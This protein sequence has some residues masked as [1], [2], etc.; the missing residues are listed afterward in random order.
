MKSYVVVTTI[1]IPYLLKDYAD[2]FEKFGH[3]NK[4][5]FIIIGDLKTP[6]EARKIS[7]ELNSR[8]FE[9]IYM[10]V[11]DQ[12]GW[13]KKFPEL[14]KIIPY[15]SD[16]RRNIG[17]LLAL[18]KGAEMILSIDDDNFVKP[19]EDWFAQHAIVGKIH[20]LEMVESSNGW[21]NICTLLRTVP[22]RIIYPRGY[23][24]S[25]R[26]KHSEVK[27]TRSKNRVVLNLGLWEGEPDVDAVT[28]L[29]ETVKVLSNS[30]RK[31]VLAKGTNSPINTQNTAV[32]HDAI[33]A[34]YYIPMGVTI[35]GN[36][37]DRYGDIWSGYFVKKV[38][39]HM[40]DAVSVGGPIVI[41]NRNPHDLLQDLK[42]ELAGM[43]LT[44][45]LVSMVDSIQ[46]TSKTYLDSYKE[47]S[48]KLKETV[49]NKNEL[50]EETKNYFYHITNSM[51]IWSDVCE[52]L[53]KKN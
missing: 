53:T 34:Y 21:F 43:I 40:G 25:K 46:L 29:N 49:Q 16:N 26:W 51:K 32:H 47:L 10:D 8:G 17:F 35:N 24:Y 7:D 33:L 36:N 30:S 3:K 22:E 14:D 41:H 50:D 18:E 39:D 2:N 52:T 44:E 23:P 37:I 20:E 4:V 12:K 1:N 42:Q 19:N 9:T 27:V 11:E 5:G 38:I 15:N 28:R 45:S 31:I 48:E 6:P 13:L